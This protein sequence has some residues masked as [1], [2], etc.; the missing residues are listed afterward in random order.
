MGGRGAYSGK[1]TGSKVINT[2]KQSEHLE[3]MSPKELEERYTNLGV[4]NPKKAELSV[5]YY[6]GEGYPEM[7]EGKYPEEVKLID[8]VIDKQPKWDGE[9]YR[10][11]R[12]NNDFIENIKNSVGDSLDF[13]SKG[14]ISFSS[15]PYV[16]RDYARSPVKDHGV[17][18]KMQNKR[19]SSI[20]HNAQY[21]S[22][23]EVLHKSAEKYKIKSVNFDTSLGVYVVE[24][25]DN[26]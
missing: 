15:N 8:E 18:F 25:E 11:M 14:P 22:E 20:S 26:D 2:S 4:S 16:A 7:R 5:R 6:T 1:S 17:L 24:L 23:G 12:V 21:P 19:G 10:G 9:I 13:G 3:M